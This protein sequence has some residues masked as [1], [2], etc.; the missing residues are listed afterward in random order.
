M[1]YRILAAASLFAMAGCS[2]V[3]EYY[4][5]SQVVVVDRAEYMARKIKTSSDNSWMATP[6]TPS[7]ASLLPDP[8][9]YERNVRAIEKASECHVIAGTVQNAFH[10]THAAVDC[11]SMPPSQKSP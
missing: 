2:T 9:I 4:P 3:N 10:T 1:K 8:A 6:N 11:S 7:A 5:G